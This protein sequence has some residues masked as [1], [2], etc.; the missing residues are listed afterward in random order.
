MSAYTP[1][2]SA[3]DAF[4]AL[5]SRYVETES[6][7]WVPAPFPGVELKVLMQDPTTGASTVL[8]RMAPGSVLPMHEHTGL[9]Q[10]FVLEGSLQDDEGVVTAGNYVWRPAGSRHMASTP[11]GCL[12]LSV[13]MTPNRFIGESD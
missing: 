11:Q 6:L 5:A 12:V 2:T 4:G 7:P 1:N 13:F 10:S 3:H 9:E 8:T